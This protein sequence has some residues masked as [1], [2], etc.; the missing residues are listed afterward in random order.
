MVFCLKRRCTSGPKRGLQ[1]Y[2]QSVYASTTMKK[3]T[4]TPVQCIAPPV[5]ARIMVGFC[6]TLFLV[7][8]RAGPGRIPED[9]HLTRAAHQFHGER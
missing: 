1:E 3:L 7:F 2:R 9:S 4:M 8:P 6:M 5:L